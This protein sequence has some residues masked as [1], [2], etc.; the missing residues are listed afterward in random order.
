M[1]RLLKCDGC[2]KVEPGGNYLGPDWAW[3]HTEANDD[4]DHLDCCS[5]SCLAAVATRR[6]VTREGLEQLAQSLERHGIPSD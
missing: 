2:G 4:A 5:W 1:T 6:A 3:V